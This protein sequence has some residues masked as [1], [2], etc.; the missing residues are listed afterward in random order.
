MLHLISLGVGLFVLWLL[1]SG[2]YTPLILFFGVVSVLLVVLVARRM[3]VV[4]REAVPTHL[5]SGILGYWIWLAKEI[6]LANYA[7]ARVIIDPKMPISPRMIRVKATQKTDLGRV[8]HANSI[9]LTPG[10]VSIELEND[11]ILVHALTAEAAEGTLEGSID[12]R[13]T[14]IEG[15]G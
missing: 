10:T 8:L 15:D 2:I 9:T 1:L 3:D 5:T 11:E 4:D 12:R 6:A 13:V 7:V 14:A